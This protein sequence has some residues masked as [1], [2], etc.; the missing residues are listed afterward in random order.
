MNGW[1]VGRPHWT[2]WAEA[3]TVPSLFLLTPPL[4]AIDCGGKGHSSSPGT[5]KLDVQQNGGQWRVA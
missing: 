5:L 4:E 1:E 2:V 3:E